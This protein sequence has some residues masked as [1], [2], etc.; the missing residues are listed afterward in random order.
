MKVLGVGEGKYIVEVDDDEMFELV[1]GNQ[2][3]EDL[4]INAGDEIS[5]T[6][7][8]RAAKWVRDLDQDH[9]DDV[10]RQ[11]NTVLHGMN[12]VKETSQALTLFA[13]L[14]DKEITND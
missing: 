11:L 2:Y 4:D 13:K 6:R 3:D 10:I 12:K 9:I 7:V 8:L 1:N 14:S 5:L